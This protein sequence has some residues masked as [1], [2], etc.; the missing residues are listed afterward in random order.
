MLNIFKK[1]KVCEY[2]DKLI[3]SLSLCFSLAW[4]ASKGIFCIRIVIEVVTAVLPFISMFISKKIIDFFV[5]S[6]LN[7]DFNK[8]ALYYFCILILGLLLINISQK[9]V[10][11][12][13]DY[14]G[15]IHKDI[16]NKLINRKIAEKATAVDLSFFDSTFF[17][18]ELN[19][20]RMDS[21]ALE[22]MTWYA[23]D[24]IRL[25]IQFIMAS[26]I[27]I[28][29]TPL[30]S[31]ALIVASIPV[32]VAENIY[33]MNLYGFQLYTSKDRRKMDY[34]ISILT[35]RM[36]AK[37][38]RLFNIKDEMLNRYE[39]IWNNWFK[40]KRGM[41]AKQSIRQTFLSIIPQICIGCALV[42]IGYN[43]L[44]GRLTVGDYSL[45]SGSIGQ[46][47]GC[48][49]SLVTLLAQI[50]DN[51]M[52]I[53]NFNRFLEWKSLLAPCGSI[54]PPSD[55]T[56]EFKDVSFKYPG[57]DK[58]VLEN[59]NF[60]IGSKEKIALVGRNG[61]G[62]STIVKLILRYYDPTE[63][64]ILINGTEI[65]EFDID[66]YRKKF[67]V[68]FQDYANYAFTVRENITIAD[69]E[70]KDNL[71]KIEDACIKSE[72]AGVVDKLG[73]GLDT[74]L[75][76]MF[77]EDGREL[78]GGEWQKIGLART[79][80]REG[81][82]IILDE[83]SAALDAEAEHNV[84]MKFAELC[85]GKGSVFISHRLANIATADKIIVLD[86]TGVAEI[87]THTG[88]MEKEGHYA[89]L[90]NLQADKYKTGSNNQ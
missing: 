83:P 34:L 71:S 48:I 6:A 75:T 53:T 64:K 26:A 89:Y 16:I 76:G 58:Y 84:F 54:M 60:C 67:T 35:G 23:I 66:A 81:E 22:A 45:Y 42:Y 52:R 28:S 15:T 40:E 43:I 80:F 57:S 68:M 70:S 79:F 36:F 25:S 24:L 65:K 72:A 11:M 69:M 14:F 37:D 19:N 62:K 46:L 56:I 38:V 1:N 27:L 3:K 74:Y 2:V 21:Y 77:E 8:N 59:V 39:K 63:G 33:K 47:D 31:V 50:H 51:N 41:A 29:L 78:S 20:V 9:A 87:G 44:Q 55:F 13:K 90:F 61:A 17:Y 82:M 86:K 4:R 73:A 7:R 32:L 5:A 88:L 85:K 49:M 10:G 12:A 18:N 30:I